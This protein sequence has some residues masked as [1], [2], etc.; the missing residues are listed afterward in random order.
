MV[1]SLFLVPASHRL[2]YYPHSHWTIYSLTY[3]EFHLLRILF[4]YKINQTSL[5]VAQSC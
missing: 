5:R 3:E 4:T 1:M 2:V